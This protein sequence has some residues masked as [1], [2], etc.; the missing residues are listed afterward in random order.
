MFNKGELSLNKNKISDTSIDDS[1]NDKLKF[2]ESI[3]P[4][5]INVISDESYFPL[6]IAITGEWGAGKTSVITLVKNKLSE[7]KGNVIIS[8]DPLIEG[9]Q[10]LRE[11]IELFYLKIIQEIDNKKI[12]KVF[13]K[14]LASLLTVSA[15]KT[16][17]KYSDPMQH[18]TIGLEKDWSSDVDKLIKIWE[19]NEPK[20]LSQHAKTINSILSRSGIK[21]YVFIDEIDRLSSEH[22]IS[23]LL[24]SRAMESIEHLVCVLGLDYNRTIRKLVVENKLGSSNYN[25]VKLY[26]DK[27]ITLS[28]HVDATLDTRLEYLCELLIDHQICNKEFVHEN[29]QDLREICDYLTTPRGIKKFIILASVNKEIISYSVNR[30]LFLKLLAIEVINPIIKEYLAKYEHI[31]YSK[32]IKNEPDIINLIKHDSTIDGIV[33]YNNSIL[34]MLL[35]ILDSR[36]KNDDLLALR[37]QIPYFITDHF[38]HSYILEILELLPRS[39]LHAYIR[40]FYKFE[41]IKVFFD[42]YQGDINNALEFLA[43][44]EHQNIA[45]DISNALHKNIIIQKQPQNINPEILDKLWLKNV[46]FLAGSPY[47]HIAK[48]LAPLVPLHIFI[49]KV[50]LYFS[51]SHIHQV[52]KAFN[53]TN[54]EGDYALDKFR[55]RPKF[56]DLYLEQLTFK[57]DSINIFTKDHIVAIL[58]QWIEKVGF[59]IKNNDIELFKMENMLDIFYRYIQWGNTVGSD[60]RAFLNEYIGCILDNN[61]VSAEIKTNFCKSLIAAK[62]FNANFRQESNENKIYEELFDSTTLKLTIETFAA[63]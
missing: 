57:N 7:S 41:F 55:S 49:D 18:V 33:Y 56:T 46:N 54:N 32:D 22:I 59:L 15:F 26:L 23:L 36:L 14:L 1:K 39:L 51:A 44:S 58:S 53:I 2:T 25:D 11:M 35:G 21:L 16:S 34:K 48:Y 8:F 47:T 29:H 40:N 28:F 60:N 27:L 13:K 37:D 42:F 45:D 24:F 4:R 17:L 62:D 38:N 3:I 52:L 6:T 9:K 61:Q 50:D 43:D 31:L 10:T 30:I 5:V 12:K 63:I 20:L 19:K